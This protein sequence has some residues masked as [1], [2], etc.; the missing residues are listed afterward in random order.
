VHEALGITGRDWQSLYH[1]SMGVPIDD[2]RLTTEP[3]YA[4]ER[5]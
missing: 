5:A 1:F 3:G 2:T 4:W